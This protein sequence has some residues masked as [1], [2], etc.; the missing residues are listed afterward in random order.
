MLTTTTLPSPSVIYF[1]SQLGPE[2][3]AAICDIKTP[4]AIEQ[5]DSSPPIPPHIERTTKCQKCAKDIPENVI[6]RHFAIWHPTFAFETVNQLIVDELFWHFDKENNCV[7]YEIHGK[8]IL[9][10]ISEQ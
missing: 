5:N 1:I 9:A 10:R 2:L 4:H 8:L 3:K 7:D 6:N